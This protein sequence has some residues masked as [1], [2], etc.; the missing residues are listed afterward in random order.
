LVYSSGGILQNVSGFKLKVL[1]YLKQS[2]EEKGSRFWILMSYLSPKWTCWD[3]WSGAFV[4]VWK[5]EVRFSLFLRGLPSAVEFWPFLHLC[6]S[7]PFTLPHQKTMKRSRVERIETSG[8]TKYNKLCWN[9][10]FFLLVRQGRTWKKK[11]SFSSLGER[12]HLP[13]CW[14]YVKFRI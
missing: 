4:L 11:K 13:K 5:G 14:I 1:V 8:K 3:G 2:I 6:L 12:L 7:S 10:V 9:K